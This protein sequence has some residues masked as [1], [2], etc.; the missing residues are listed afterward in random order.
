MLGRANHFE[1]TAT[2]DASMFSDS[3][4][5]AFDAVVFLNTTGDVLNEKQQVAFEQYIAQGGGFVGIHSAADTEYDWPWYGGLVGAYFDS[6]PAIQQ[7]TVL[8]P[9]D[10]HPS[11]ASLS[12]RW[13]RVDE[14]YNY[15]SNPR[16]AVHVLAV[17]DESTYS[18]GAQPA[19]HPISW[20]HLY[21]GGRSWY[22]G[23]GHTEETYSEPEFL[24]HIKGGIA[25]AIGE[26]GDCSSTRDAQYQQTVLDENPV[27]PMELTVT[28]DGVALYVELFGTV[29]KYDPATG[30]TSIV[31]NLDVFHEFEDGLT[32][33]TLDPEFESNGWVYLFYSPAGDNAVQHVSRF[34]FNGSTIDPLSERILLKIPV[35]RDQCCHTAGALAFGPDGNLFISTGDNTNPFESDG[36]APLDERSGRAAWDAQGSSGNTNDLRGKILRIK[37]LPNGTYAIPDGNLFPVDTDSTRPEIYITGTRNPFRFSIDHET[38]WLY[39][40]DVGPD[41]GRYDRARGPRGHDEWNRAIE[42]GNFGWPYCIGNNKPYRDY[43]L[44]TGNS[45]DFFD[46]TAPINDSPNNTGLRKL[47]PARNAWIWYPYG[48]SPDFPQLD[49]N[50]VGRTAAA[51]P[52]YHFDPDLKSSRKLPRYFDKSLFI[53]EWSRNWIKEIKFDD[54]GDI[55]IIQ[56]FLSSFHFNSVIDM[57]LGPD[58]ALY[59]LEWGS[60][61]FSRNNTDARLL[62]IEFN[63]RNKA[64]VATA[65]ASPDAGPLPL[66]VQFDARRSFDPDSFEEL[67][68]EWDFTSDGQ[69]DA[70]DPTPTYTFTKAGLHNVRLTVRDRSGS[71]GVATVPIVAGNSRPVVSIEE[72]ANGSFFAWGQSAS[73]TVKVEDA[74]DGRTEAGID[75]EEVETQPAIGHDAHSH[76]ERIYHGCTGTF[77]LTQSHGADGSDVFYVIETTYTDQGGEAN[78][79]LTG[80]AIAILQPLRK[81]AEHF[82][83]SNRLTIVSADD[84]QGLRAVSR[85]TS[86]EYIALNPVNLAGIE[87]I[88]YRLNPAVAG[89]E[90][91]VHV[92]SIN[93]LR[94][95]SLIITDELW[96]TGY[97]DITT[98][99]IDPGGIHELY[100]VFENDSETELLGT[101]NYVDFISEVGTSTYITS[102]DIENHFFPPFPNPANTSIQF[103]YTLRKPQS[104][105]IEIYTMLGRRVALLVDEVQNGGEHS[106]VM[107]KGHL[108]SGTYI[109]RIR[110]GE[111][112]YSHGF[113]VA[114]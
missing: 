49:G 64:P 76:G 58:G 82:R 69:I 57:E 77:E 79:P 91:S 71:V 20:C 92:D 42:A 16:G 67:D 19:D 10:A 11:T 6:H 94:I 89:T 17:L 21:Q 96:G 51:G 36:F 107:Q 105:R 72:P 30:T 55:L 81:E 110:I 52:V 104:V 23:M 90:I 83:L 98:P 4:L 74:E 70:T 26:G 85:I 75:C 87:A 47:P 95:S 88:S 106:L 38:G 59:L 18:G 56:P 63:P 33:I 99:I 111:Q 114:Q 84:S 112:Y 25:F 27:N 43:D 100:F 102:P 46:C 13:H 40:G 60:D 50:G 65:E 28:P 39:W 12:Q 109:C 48:E 113:I 61:K 68:Y 15:K 93:G 14:W 108:A 1:V 86:G 29:K 62:R 78:A 37:P 31:L 3:R 5:A 97:I 44:G 8:I 101:L 24:E 7:G 34:T 35:Q 32:G 73:Y 2:E 66:T 41:A 45:G 53:Y 9:D 80:Q 103:Q 54:Q 22:T